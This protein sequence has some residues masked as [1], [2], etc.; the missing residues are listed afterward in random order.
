M[1][2]SIT[3]SSAGLRVALQDYLDK[4]FS[5]GHKPGGQ[6]SEVH[7]KQEYGNEVEVDGDT[8]IIVSLKESK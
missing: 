3:I 2:K 1:I 4:R 7:F 8:N 6:I 5:E